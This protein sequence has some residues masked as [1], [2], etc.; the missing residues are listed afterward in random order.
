MFVGREDE[1]KQLLYYLE[2]KS[3]ENIVIYGRRRIGKSYLIKETLKRY[4]KSFIFYQAKETTL[5]DNIISISKIISEHYNLGD[6]S[7]NSIEA[8]FEFI[9]LKDDGV[10]FVIDEYPYLRELFEGLDSVIQKIIDT[11]K[12]KSQVKI[13]LLGSYIDVMSKLSKVDNPLYGRISLMMFVSKMN[14]YDASSFYPNVDL[15]TKVKYYSVFDGVPYYNSLIKQ[16]DSFEENIK[17]IIIDQNSQ[18]GDFIEITLS[19]ELRKINGANAVF[20]II[21]NGANK[22]NDILKRLSGFSSSSL[23][24]ILNNLINMDL[25]KKVT[26][27]NEPSNSKRTYYEINDNYIEFY[28]RYIFRNNSSRIILKSE[29]FYNELIKEDFNTQYVPKKFE[30]IAYEYLIKENKAGNI[31]PPLLNIGKYWYDNPIEKIN[32]EFDLVTQDKSGFI[33]YEVKYK[34]TKIDIKVVDR[35]IEQLKKC[36]VK[37]YNVGFFSKSG[38]DFENENNYYLITLQNIYDKSN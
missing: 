35:L 15:E 27:I 13:V 3:Q 32:G 36:N 34:N 28:Y 11:Y 8:I 14:Y 37:Y 29:D 33:V 26:P 12:N 21:A 2:S 18:L 19:K 5:E 30:K 7:F 9:F 20:S 23:S 1:I 16:E 17:R 10:V 31:T 24:A 22:F 6:V 4:G 25:L 38:F